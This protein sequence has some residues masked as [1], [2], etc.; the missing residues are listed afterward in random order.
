MIL[1]VI[2]GRVP[3]KLLMD[4]GERRARLARRQLLA[5][6]V[7]VETPL[8]V[9]RSLV[10]LHGTDP[11]TVYLSAAARL[12]RPSV[13]DI[14]RAMYDDRVLVRM[15]GMRRTMFVVA[16]E[17]APAIQ[18]ACTRT[19]AVQLRRRYRQL[20]QDAGIAED[21]ASFMEAVEEATLAAL[22]RRRE[23]TAQE[24]GQDVPALRKQVRLAQGKNYEGV[25]GISTW[26]LMLLSADG[27]VIR[28]R[29]RGSWI[30][31]QYRWAPLD[32]WLP[33]GMPSVPVPDAQATLIGQWLRAFGPGTLDDLKWWTGLT[34][35]EVK[36]AVQALD[37][38][39]VDLGEA[40]GLV[41]ADDVA[42][43]TPPEAWVALLPGLDPTP[44]GY[45]QREWFLGP[46]ASALFD[47][48]GNIGPSIWS[49]G[50]IVGGWAQRKNGAVAFKLLEDIGHEAERC[51]E[52][53]AEEL[54]R[55]LGAVRITPRFRT[56]LE[57]ELSA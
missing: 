14:E 30:S 48:S 44:M 46:H 8:E 19:I 31:S 33:N 53:A 57:R 4:V 25:Q 27:K 5:E 21:A 7:H 41:L 50:R 45:V 15:L 6:S 36:R 34:M 1:P 18:A 20:L 49:D 39:E 9:A 29:P 43:T 47:R 55:W 35:G 37:V 52:V 38:V 40:T 16:D 11:A 22:E 10:A 28:G 32:A 56:P 51:V 26:I 17:L 12:R 42:P 13:A 24:L 2:L 3:S 54:G 23:A